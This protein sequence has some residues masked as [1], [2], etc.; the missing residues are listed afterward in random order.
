[1]LPSSSSALAYSFLLFLFDTGLIVPSL[2]ACLLFRVS[3]AC[4]LLFPLLARVSFFPCLLIQAP[5]PPVFD[6]IVFPS[7]DQQQ[8]P[9]QSSS[10]QLMPLSQDWHISL[11]LA[12]VSVSNLHPSSFILYSPFDIYIMA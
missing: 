1:V 5:L 10:F 9:K 8:R 6:F 2:L 3:F 7:E 12:R 11:H 4:F